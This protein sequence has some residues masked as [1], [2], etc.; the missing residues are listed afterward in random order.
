MQRKWPFYVLLNKC[1]C[2]S[3]RE[4]VSSGAGRQGGACKGQMVTQR[5]CSPTPSPF[6]S[7]PSG[8]DMVS[9][10][11][12]QNLTSSVFFQFVCSPHLFS[13]SLA[14]SSLKVRTG[15]LAYPF[16]PS[17]PLPSF[18]SS[19]FLSGF[20][21]KKLFLCACDCH[22]GALLTRHVGLRRDLGFV[23]RKTRL[24]GSYEGSLNIIWL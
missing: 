9:L 6:F 1:V 10:S 24:T 19:A 5:S 14:T 3:V 23:G 21:L 18:V 4:C 16:K 17:V 8:S 12:L 22:S 7:H 11:P 13:A 2:V 20:L 15:I